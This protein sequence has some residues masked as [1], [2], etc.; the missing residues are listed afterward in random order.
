MYLLTR[1]IILPG[2]HRRGEL[3]QHEPLLHHLMRPR[4]PKTERTKQPSSIQKEKKN[5]CRTIRRR[6]LYLLR[7][8]R[9]AAV[10]G[11]RP[12]RPSPCRCCSWRTPSRSVPPASA[13]V[14][15][16]RRA[17]AAAAGHGGR[18]SLRGARGRRSRRRRAGA[19]RRGAGLGRGTGAPWRGAGGGRGAAAGAAATGA[20]GRAA[21]AFRRTG[22]GR[23]RRLA[24]VWVG[25]AGR[26]R[27]FVSL[28]RGLSCGVVWAA[29]SS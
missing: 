24:R 12:A 28:G 1:P 3:E 29:G 13:E 6:P 21:V 9:T 23:R 16:T 10:W 2:R 11:R 20:R 14:G 25:V 8:A 15:R 4:L 22:W 27:G 5:K 26:E 17:A 18:S 19:S 7:A